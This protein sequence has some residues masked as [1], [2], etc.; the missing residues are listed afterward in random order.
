[1][2]FISWGETFVIAG[3]SVYVIGRKDLPRA[4]RFL[5]VQVGRVVG[6]LQGA[7]VRADRFTAQNELR[8]LQNEFRSGLRELESVRSEMAISMSS[9]GLVGRTLG[10]TVPGVNKKPIQSFDSNHKSAMPKADE[11]LS[12]STSSQAAETTSQI[13]EKIDVN[14]M[15]EMANQGQN[16]VD[17]HAIDH[18]RALAPRAHSVAAVAEEEWQKQ[19]IGF[20]SVAERRAD[21]DSGSSMLSNLYQQ[22][23]IYDQHDRVVQERDEALRSRFVEAERRA[24]DQTEKK[25]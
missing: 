3:V 17:T 20:Q 4:A 8:Q 19:G 14:S 6:L 22:S 23:L 10:S 13:H 9:Q 1:M 21:D 7:R 18:V 11:N 25:E 2:V 12:L 5:G 16:N 24:K 15:L